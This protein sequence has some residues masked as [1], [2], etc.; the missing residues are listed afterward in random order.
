MGTGPCGKTGNGGPLISEG[1]SR[2]VRANET[3]VVED[4]SGPGMPCDARQC[5]YKVWSDS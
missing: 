2:F 5:V 4:V 1:T 3:H